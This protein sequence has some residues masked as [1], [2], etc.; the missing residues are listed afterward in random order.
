MHA[1]RSPHEAYRRVEFDARVVGAD[2]RQLVLVC[3]DQLTGA[4]GRALHGARSGDNRLKSEALTRALAAIAALQMGI[5]PSAPIASVLTQF[6]GSARRAL[7]DCVLNFDPL[8]VEQLKQD[9]S[10]IRN[11]LDQA[12]FASR[13]E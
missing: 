13:S 3:Y 12:E 9:F 11:T 10:E 6:Y 5:D 7:L 8:V 2:P 4:L 1:L